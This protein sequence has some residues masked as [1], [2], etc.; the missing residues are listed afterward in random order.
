MI[1]VLPAGGMMNHGL[2]NYNAK[3]F[4]HLCRENN[5]GVVS[6]TVADAGANPVPSDIVSSNKELGDGWHGLKGGEV[7][8]FMI[9]ATL[10]KTSPL[11]FVT[12]LDIPVEIIPRQRFDLALTVRR[13]LWRMSPVRFSARLVRRI[14][15]AR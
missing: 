6:L 7:P 15:N 12:P 4:W 11:P 3:F 14:M 5:Y 2:I 1:H 8:D 13:L 10:R 9:Y